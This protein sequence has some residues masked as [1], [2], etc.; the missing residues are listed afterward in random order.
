MEVKKLYLSKKD[1]KIAGV[2]GGIAE[3]FDVDST[4]IRVLF[5]VSLFLG[6][7]LPIVG[8]FAVAFVIPQRPS[9]D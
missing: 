2:C 4:L 1:K 6:F 8:Y 5:V 9:E 7:F 3:Y